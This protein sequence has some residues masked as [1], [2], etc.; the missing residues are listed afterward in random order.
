MR[1]SL[2]G[3]ESRSATCMLLKWVFI[4]RE[5]ESKI[6]DGTTPILF[7]PKFTE[8]Q[9]SCQLTLSRDYSATKSD[10]IPM[11]A[12]AKGKETPLSVSVL[13]Q[14]ADILSLESDPKQPLTGTDAHASDDG[15]GSRAL[16]LTQRSGNL[17]RTSGTERVTERDRTTIRVHLVVVQSECVNRHD[18]LKK[19]ETRGQYEERRPCDV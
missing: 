13:R 8:R 11:P 9:G 16:G 18:G 10:A 6:K 12:R 2:S 1:L 4:L 17:A 7:K 5:N 15:L 3:R 14:A 19:T